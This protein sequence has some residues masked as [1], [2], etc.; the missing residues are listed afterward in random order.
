[1][2]RL[3]VAFIRCLPW[4][5]ACVLAAYAS[6]QDTSTIFGTV[7]DAS[8]GVIG[9]VKVDLI[10]VDRQITTEETSNALGEYVFTP[11]RV[12][13]YEIK[14]AKSGFES[15]VHTN[16]V[17]QVQQRM[18]V[19]I[20]M[21]VGAVNQSVEVTEASPLLETGTSSVGQVINN[22]SITELPLN[23]R[24]YQQLAVMSSGAVPTGQTSRGPSDFSANGARPISNN[25]LLDGMDNN[26]YILDLQNASSESMAPSIDA[27]Q[28]FKVQNNSFSA[29][30]GRYGGAV[31]N[32]TIKSGTNQFHG[33]LFE[34]LRNSAMDANNFF[35]NRAGIHLAPF[36]QNQFG[37]TLGGPFIRNKLFF[38][39]S[40]QGTRVAQGV[41]YVSTV[42]TTAERNGVFPVA[43]Y[44]PA[45]LSGNTRT[46]FPN[47]TIPSSRFDSTGAKTFDTYPLPN[48]PGVANN[49]ILN[50]PNTFTADQYDNRVD[51]NITTH[52][53]FFGRYSLTENVL[54]SPG[55]LPPPAS[56]QPAAGEIPITAHSGVLGETHTFSPSVVNE[57]RGGVNRLDAVRLPEVRVRNI[58]DFGFKGIPFY[59]DIT[60]L[61]AIGVT[62]YTGLGE[63]GTIP[64]VKL[65]QVFQYSDSV[66]INHRSH[67]FKT[68]ADLRY[69]QSN[70]WTPSSTRGSFSFTGVY[71]QNPQNRSGNGS[72]LAD[73]LLGI[74]ASATMTTPTVGNFRQRY[75]GFYFQDDWQVNQR[76]TLNLGVRWDLDSPFW[77]HLN[78]MSNF[79]FEPGAPNYGQL[80]LAGSQGESIRD[81]ALVQFVKDG[82]V[83][84][85]GLAYRFTNKL[86]LRTAWGIFNI[87]TPLAGINGRLSYNP[88]WTASYSY[89]SDQINPLFTLATGFPASALV[90]SINQPN[91]ALT[92]W[93]PNMTNGYLE[94]WN[95]GLEDQLKPNLLATILYSASAGHHLPNSRN[96]NQPP[97]GPGATQPRSPFPQYTTITLFE[98]EANSTYNS[99]QAKLEQRFSN[100]LTF[101]ANYTWSHFIDQNEPVLDTSGAGIQN[102]YNLGAERGNSNYDVRQRFVTS[103]AYELPLGKGRK[104]LNHGVGAAILGGWQLNGVIAAQSGNPFTPT[105]NVNVANVTGSTQRPNRIASGVI[106]YGSRT[107]YQWFKVSDFVSPA[108]YNFG[109]SGRNILTGPRLFQWDSSLFRTINI[110]ENIRLQFRAEVFNIVNHPDF[111]VPNAVIGTAAAGTISS[112]IGNSTLVAEPVG[113]P[114][115]IQFALKLLF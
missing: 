68:G 114:R 66:Y 49:F 26:S 17:P 25:Y 78:R 19:D 20:T 58:E 42:P 80:V 89:S 24:D 37:G 46:V 105:Y 10:D 115:Q 91:R 48:Q 36:R 43:I 11:V 2:S 75:Y 60:G 31:I 30:L 12:G 56:G 112:L 61:P 64:N 3:A 9:G 85:V 87:G 90:A 63:N 22:K 18:R 28:E 84:R 21:T 23:G 99:L 57:F 94:Q 97:P 83:P 13:R 29:E 32:A 44:D 51:Y 88:P 76:L 98:S 54:V 104:Y 59:S 69:I 71:T 6:A 38:F 53:Q 72:G 45:T 74:P 96:I 100:G 101:L 55:A 73:L 39:G 113:Q 67:S 111:G 86:V 33:D 93:D 50:P 106:P 5:T 110:R 109:N 77:D 81:R 7:T 41:T 82:I 4:F 40:Y 79:V 1:M 16:L 8:G 103:Y 52:D 70:A 15:V 62:G 27:L 92:P 102:N 107:V 47:N 108:Q 95:F 35:N 34:F 65:S 14:A